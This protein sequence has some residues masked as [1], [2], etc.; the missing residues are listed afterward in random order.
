[1]TAPCISIDTIEDKAF[2]SFIFLCVCIQRFLFE[3]LLN[4]PEIRLYFII[5]NDWFGTQ[6]DVVRLLFQI[7]RKMVNTIWFRVDLIRFF[8][9]YDV[10]E[11]EQE[12]EG[13]IFCQCWTGKEREND[14]KD[15]FFDGEFVSI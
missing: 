10:I 4:Q 11:V 14:L 3:V 13:T 9:V 8:C 2:F 5:F 7:D 12:R 1:M 6:T 15:H